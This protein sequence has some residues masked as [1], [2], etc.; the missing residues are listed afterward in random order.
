MFLAATNDAG[1]GNLDA[2]DANGV[3][4]CSGTP[5]TC[6][7]LWTAAL[8]SGNS[9]SSPTV[10]NGIVYISDRGNLYAFDANGVTGCSGTPKT[11]SPL[12]SSPYGD[13][14]V[15][16]AD[17]S[18][19]A[20][21]N[22]V[23]YTG[24]YGFLHAFDANGVTGCSGTPKVCSPLWSTFSESVEESFGSPVVANGLVYYFGG[25]YD[26]NGVTGCSGTPK[27]CSPL[28]EFG[29][30]RSPAIANGVLY[31]S[32]GHLNKTLLHAY[33]A[34]TGAPLWSSTAARD[35]VN[36]SPV[37][38]NG[39]V[40]IAA[41]DDHLYAFDASGTTGCS[42]TPKICAP[43]ASFANAGEWVSAAIANGRVYIDGYTFGLP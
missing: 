36:A 6:S 40:Y 31:V 42:V 13:A 16:D 1:G 23:V 41:D 25:A 43:L 35:F 38:A 4:G 20:V 2:Y 18:S 19:P 9:N 11:C 21:A 27:V 8:E 10:A 22:G 39:V 14:D 5:K 34:L 12:W 29:N 24:G 32:G 37:V 3:T 17:Q 15:G 30:G 7:P 26:A 28:W 33:N